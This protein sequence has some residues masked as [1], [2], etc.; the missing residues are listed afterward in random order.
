M[1]VPPQPQTSVAEPPFKPGSQGWTW[2]ERLRHHDEVGRDD[3]GPRGPSFRLQHLAPKVQFGQARVGVSTGEVPSRSGGER[4][5]S[6]RDT[7]AARAI[8]SN[9]G[10]S[11]R[12][13]IAEGNGR[14]APGDRRQFFAIA[15][16]SAHECEPHEDT[17]SWR[18]D[19][20]ERTS[21]ITL[22]VHDCLP[23]GQ[24]SGVERLRSDHSFTAMALHCDGPSPRWRGSAIQRRPCRWGP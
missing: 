15:R 3:K 13:R 18:G 24:E 23:E 22:P 9:G 2:V 12:T 21:P 1:L 14:F 20:G 11:S 17:R 19:G 5:A 6:P 16:G 7:G 8:R 4:P 10:T